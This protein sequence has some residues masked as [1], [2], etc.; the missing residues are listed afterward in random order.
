VSAPTSEIGHAAGGSSSSGWWDAPSDEETPELRW[1]NSTRVYDAMRRQDA[2]VASVLRAVSMPVMRTPW[3][4]DPAGARDEVVAHIAEDLGL[5]IVGDPAGVD[6]RPRTRDRFSWAHHLEQALLDLAFGH[7][8]FEQ[9][10]RLDA[11]GRVRLRKLGPRMPRTLSA[12]NVADDGGL[13]SIE[14]YPPTTSTSTMSTITGRGRSARPIV[15]PVSRLVAYVHQREAGDWTGKSLLRPAYKHWLLKDRLL[16]VQTMAIERNGLGMPVYVGAEGE[17][18]LEGGRELAEGWRAGDEAGVAVPYGAKLLLQG[19]E[20]AVPDANPP[21]RYHDEQIAKSVLAHLLT[22]GQQT[23]SWALGRTFEE[24]L[25]SSLQAVGE[26]HRD[27]AQQHVVED[28]V[29]LNWGPDETAP[30]LVF[31]EIGSRQSADAAALKSLADAGILL[32][33]KSLEEAVRELLGL[34]P[35]DPIRLPNPA[36]APAPTQLGGNTP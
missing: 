22:L 3:R 18:N 6:G 11:A 12:I 27:T 32:P 19:V 2:Q 23:G 15:I 25:T 9:L 33:D 36:P 7:M 29:D 31:E 16:R 4:I 14:Q 8:Y 20:G 21:I 10:Y 35:K 26:L 13:I 1:P 24:L 34:P 17:K 30:R 28:L 5:P